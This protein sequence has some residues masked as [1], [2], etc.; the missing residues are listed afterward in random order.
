MNTNKINLKNLHFQELVETGNNYIREQNLKFAEKYY[1]EAF[2]KINSAS[3]NDFF[4]LNYANCKLQLEKYDEA[5]KFYEHA[6]SLNLNLYPAY[7]SLVLCEIALFNQKKYLDPLRAFDS[8]YIKNGLELIKQ[9]IKLNPEDIQN[10]KYLTILF[11]ELDD[12][13][14][15]VKNFKKYLFIKFDFSFL[16]QY[17]SILDDYGLNDDIYEICNFWLNSGKLN[18]QEIIYL[19]ETL[20]NHYLFLN[21]S[22]RAEA[23]LIE[24]LKY[25]KFFASSIFQLNKIRP[26]KTNDDIVKNVEI[27]L[28]KNF[29]NDSENSNAISISC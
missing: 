24:C 11:Y 3:S 9:A 27:G 25:R 21:D 12:L 29:F 10:Y 7:Q 5:K 20:S 2:K 15:V 22:S 13:E 23:L 14:N 17:F 26:F 8:T 16:K 6:L 1:D 4:Y 28:S 19:K 18:E